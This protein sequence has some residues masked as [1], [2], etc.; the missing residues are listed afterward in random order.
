MEY[1]FLKNSNIPVDLPKSLKKLLQESKPCRQ[2]VY[3][4][5]GDN[6]QDK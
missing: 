6:D 5:V 4:P 1:W 2:P 3:K